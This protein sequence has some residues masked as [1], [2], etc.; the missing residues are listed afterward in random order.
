M[1]DTK[2][3]LFA[4]RCTSPGWSSRCRGLLWTAALSWLVV[5]QTGCTSSLTA[6]ALRDA[7]REIAEY[8]RRGDEVAAEEKEV[9]ADFSEGEEMLSLEEALDSAI[10][11]LAAVG[12]LDAEARQMLLETLE[13]TSQEDWPIVIESFASSLE[14]HAQGTEAIEQV[15]EQL[16]MEASEAEEPADEAVAAAE[17]VAEEAPAGAAAV[18]DE[19]ATSDQVAAEV[20]AMLSDEQQTVTEP[21]DPPANAEANGEAMLVSAAADVSPPDTDTAEPGE[22]EGEAATPLAEVEPG[23]SG[24]DAGAVEA[25]SPQQ[26]PAVTADLLA[27]AAE[28]ASSAAD[29]AP[30][31]SSGAPAS[32]EPH[33]AVKAESD[34]AT[35]AASTVDKDGH[36]APLADRVTSAIRELPVQEAPVLSP[37]ETMQRLEEALAIA[38][39][40]AP[41]RV[42]NPCFAWQVRAWGDVER[43]DVSR[44]HSGQ[45]VIVYF[46][47]DNLTSDASS[48]GHT[49]KLDTELRLVNTSGECLHEWSFPPLAEQCAAPRRD[50]FAR[51][52]LEVP[53]GIS[54]G[55]LRLEMT[56]N[57]LLGEKSAAVALPLE[58]VGEPE[59]DGE[60]VASDASLLR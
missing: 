49:T 31:S 23:E 43:C 19:R 24:Q 55:P 5:C 22:P 51:Y 3:N 48:A 60:R 1:S 42:E 26:V 39:R 21:I 40:Q 25:T 58:V 36:P 46:E 6:I 57:D 27:E 20:P 11:R 52:I 9:V 7:M 12:R 35:A 28:S 38:R 50:Y 32:A 4:E 56:V 37:E 18:E 15:A 59:L 45:Q 10:T 54:P 29:S 2:T 44:F 8:G 16:E 30:A 34:V 41:L 17:P 14:E 47:V 53:A 33:P 13:S